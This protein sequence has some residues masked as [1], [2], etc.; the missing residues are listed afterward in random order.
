MPNAS[1]VSAKRH[2][3]T[4]SAFVVAAILAIVLVVPS[5]AAPN[6]SGSCKPAA[7]K[8]TNDAQC[9]AGLVCQ[10]GSCLAG[11][12]IG[13]VFHAKRASNPAN[14]C[15]SCRPTVSTT[16]WTNR[17]NGT[18][19]S[20]GNAC[21]QTDRCQAGVC[22]GSN[23]VVCTASDGCHLAGTCDPSTGACPNP[24]KADGTVCNDGNAC[25]RTDTCQ[26][27]LCTGG[28]PVVCAAKDQ[29]HATGTCDGT[30]GR[31]SD[32]SKPDGVACNDGSACTSN[33]V[34]T[35]GV[36]GGRQYSCVSANPC[37]AGACNG[38]GTCSN[39]NVAD[40]TPCSALSSSGTCGSGICLISACQ[41][42]YADCDG[43]LSNGCEVK[44]SDDADN[45][46]ACGT[47]CMTGGSCSM[48]A[49]TWCSAGTT[50]QECR[51]RLAVLS[52]D[53]AGTVSA[54][55]ENS[56]NLIS[57]CGPALTEIR[58]TTWTYRNT[59][60]VADGTVLIEEGDL[61]DP[62]RALPLADCFPDKV[63]IRG[64]AFL[65]GTDLAISGITTFTLADGSEHSITTASMLHFEPTSVVLQ[66]FS[67]GF[68]NQGTLRVRPTVQNPNYVEAETYRWSLLA[69]NESA[70]P[71]PADVSSETL[72][73]PGFKEGDSVTLGLEYA[74]SSGTATQ[75]LSLTNEFAFSSGQVVL[76]WSDQTSAACLH[77]LASDSLYLVL[78]PVS[79]PAGWHIIEDYAYVWTQLLPESPIVECDRSL[80][81]CGGSS[82][83]GSSPFLFVPPNALEVCKSYQWSVAVTTARDDAVGD[84]W[85][86]QLQSCVY[87]IAGPPKDGTCHLVT[88]PEGCVAPMAN[89]QIECSDW[90]PSCP[91]GPTQF[92]YSVRRLSAATGTYYA[93]GDFDSPSFSVAVGDVSETLQVV[94]GDALGALSDPIDVAVGVCAPSPVPTPTPPPLDEA[95]PNPDATPDPDAPPTFSDVNPTPYPTPTA[96][97][98][99]LQC[100]A[101]QFAEP[102]APVCSVCPA[103]TSSEA[104]SSV[105]TPCRQGTYAPAPGSA[106]CLPCDAGTFASDTGQTECQACPVGWYAAGIG[107]TA[108]TECPPGTFA[109]AP[110]SKSCISAPPTSSEVTP[111]PGPS[112]TSDVAVQCPAGQFAESGASECSACPAGTYSE[113]GSSL[114][115]ACRRGTYAPAPGSAECLPCDAGKF[116]SDTGQI[117]CQ[118]CPAGYAVDPGA[119]GCTACQ[120]GKFA[121]APGS[122]TCA[123]CTEGTVAPAPETTQCAPC[124]ANATSNATNTLCLC[125][126]GYYGTTVE[127]VFTCLVCP[128]GADCT[129][130]GTTLETLTALPGWWRPTPGQF[131]Q[132]VLGTQCSGVEN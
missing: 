99:A 82:A 54:A 109:V 2:S 5:Q 75:V 3:A 50:C 49:C 13:E 64:G 11:C 7:R 66:S 74:W 106:Q 9:C 39:V 52:L 33:D 113:A 70:P 122:T 84:P 104:G 78:D 56:L 73:M 115:I 81:D 112:P 105:C 53:G 23:P 51:A 16:A 129:Q 45:C 127:G 42:D 94:V 34:C 125:D 21:T 68:D 107:A 71:L 98:V 61:C 27:G 41:D 62:E 92:R 103:G 89:A 77:Q 25:T 1:F 24:S 18:T 17:A 30:T 37:M 57:D 91:D 93:L 90:V 63:V 67:G 131:D 130:P 44:I 38:D 40:G 26:Q 121:A 126:A 79:P 76:G 117:E 22:Q 96:S 95:T 65:G 85:V 4:V 110:G 31:C 6:G 14:A 29:C 47:V 58:S 72:V 36:C 108:C 120:P 87:Q 69:S 46:G 83:D 10:G 102:G 28:N 48:G 35:T 15:Q 60:E 128:E 8:C 19:C 12:R 124:P 101:G 80:Y 100:P 116:A 88:G 59:V 55:V 43:D 118:V 114:C 111:T 86:T 97:D 123:T 20:D 119:T 132:C 32:P